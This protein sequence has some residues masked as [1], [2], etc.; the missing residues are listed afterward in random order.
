VT[1]T[2]REQAIEALETVLKTVSPLSPAANSFSLL[3]PGAGGTTYFSD[4]YR[5]PP[6]E[7]LM[8]AG[9]Q[10]V[11]VVLERLETKTEYNFPVVACE[12]TVDVEI[13]VMKQQDLQ[14]SKELS[15]Y[16]GM[17]D[18][19]VRQNRTLGGLIIDLRLVV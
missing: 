13:H 6:A 11:A 7:G 18:W 17:V 15:R 1:E 10:A 4:V 9:K 8:K 19:V 16:L 12:L 2:I 5:E 14:M 3:T